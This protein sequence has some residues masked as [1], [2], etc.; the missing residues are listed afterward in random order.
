MAKYLE[1]ATESRKMF[2]NM[3]FP[4]S[5]PSNEVKGEMRY[6]WRLIRKGFKIKEVYFEPLHFIL[7]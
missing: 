4:S 7:H 1:I 6:I 2:N 3:I 5:K